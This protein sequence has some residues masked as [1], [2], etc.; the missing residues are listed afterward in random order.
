[1]KKTNLLL[2]I[3]FLFLAQSSFAQFSIGGQVSFLKTFGDLSMT[4]FGAGI[5]GEWGEEKLVYYGGLN[6]Y[7]AK[8]FKG[9]T[10]A[11]ALSDTTEP[12]SILVD[13]TTSVS[14]LHIFGGAKYYFIG[15]AT[16]DFGCYGLG[17]AGLLL[18]PYKVTIGSYDKTLYSA[19]D[20]EF[21]ETLGGFMVNFGVGAEVN[22]NF[23][24]LFGD[25]KL[26]LPASGISSREETEGMPASLSINAGVRFPL[27]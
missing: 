17:E 1:M 26:N 6:Y 12:G 8:K 19:R 14:F 3:V 18:A 2:G 22:L 25:V 9:T 16:E 13:M 10:Y 7:L 11:N 5:K 21:Q 24:Y 20:E 4:N 23:G 27:N 15:E